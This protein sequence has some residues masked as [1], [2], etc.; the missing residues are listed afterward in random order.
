MSDLLYGLNEKQ[1]QAVSTRYKH[2]L[3]LAGAGSGKT[4]VLVHRIAWLL[5]KDNISPSSIL[6]VTFTNKAAAEMQ[7]RIEKLGK[8][9]QGMWIG[10]FHSLAHRLLRIH[11]LDANLSQD[12][13]VLDS[14]DQLRLV[15]GII[16]SLNLDE[17]KWSSR[18]AIRYINNQKDMML[19][20]ENIENNIK[21]VEKI[22]LRIYQTY[23]DACHRT[24][25][26]DFSELLL[27]VQ[28]LLINKPYILQHYRQRFSHI[29]VDEF[30]DTNKIQYAWIRLLAGDQATV[31]I[32]G[33]DDQ[34][35]Y[36]WRGAQVENIKLFLKN[37]TGAET[38]RLEQNYRSTHQIL[39]A[40][41]S[42]I[43]NNTKRMGKKLW[44]ESVIGE[45]ISI[46]SA[47]NELDEARFV[48][49]K[50]KTWKSQGGLLKDCAIL[51]RSN[52]QSRILEDVLLQA[53]VLY[54]IYGGQRFFERQEIKDAL[55]YLRLI[56]NRHDDIAF[57]RVVNTPLRGIGDRTLETIRQYARDQQLT[58][59]KTT[60][61]FLQNRILPNRVSTS[62]KSFIELVESLINETANMPLHSLTERVIDASGLLT[63]Y[64]EEKGEKG[65]ARIENLEELITATQEYLHEDQTILP[66]SAFLSYAA[67]ESGERQED[68]DQDAVQLMTLHSSKGLEFLQ[69]L[70][71][72][73]EEGIFPSQMALSENGRLEEERRLA[74]VGLTRAMK[75]LTLSYTKSRRL[76][77]KDVHHLPSRFISE[78]PIECVEAVRLHMN[79]SRPNHR[80]ISQSQ[81][82]K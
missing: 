52:A 32:V 76:Y 28:E 11:H 19:R 22:W 33:D 17:K 58:L 37:F 40:A 68:S 26:V 59:W 55:A 74:Y 5:S 61:I 8:A 18:Q 41:N 71:V 21:P 57:E 73:M 34:S 42:L 54:R 56:S 6:A 12:F 77:G 10:T 4:R 16:K 79:V 38:L 81:Y 25:L 1:R 43:S 48:V 36:G 60:L 75:K 15:R 30:Q 53:K 64:K 20:P 70:I 46:Y 35:I 66:L 13:Q 72:G 29:L 65:Q 45:A 51:Y 47:I 78:L 44:T 3:V 50:I 27:R 39:T 2:L 24:D 82:K 9:H 63:M 23:Q 69:V 14:D 80:F 62:L 67:L 31:M 7:H 49:N